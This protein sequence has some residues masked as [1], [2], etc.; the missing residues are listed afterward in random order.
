[1]SE[2]KVIYRFSDKGYPK[3]KIDKVD[4]ENCFINFAYN[5][6]NCDGKGVTLL[7]DNCETTTVNSFDNILND[8]HIIDDVNVIQTSEGNAGSYKFAINYA[9][10]N[11]TDD[12]IVYFVEG[13]FIH[14]INSKNI[15]LQAFHMNEIDIDYATLY[16]RPD[17]EL[18]D[19]ICPEYIF[20]T[21]DCY[22]RTCVSTVMTH[23]TRVKTLKV[24]YDIIMKYCSG[25]HPNDQE[26]FSELRRA[27]Q[28]TLVSSIPGYSTHGE[29]AWLSPHK[30]W[31]TILRQS[32]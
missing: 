16:A 28:R 6:L 2:L 24:D 17:K 14:D 10:K 11:F 7:E 23:A 13:D 12:T 22:W 8:L 15:L 20:R 32:L 4:N 31:E 27:K 19:N 26:M 21:D 30:D 5:F 9:I 29:T 3:N 1:M 25:K 18:I